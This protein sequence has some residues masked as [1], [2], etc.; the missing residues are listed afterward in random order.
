M[1]VEQLINYLR[2]LPQDSTVQCLVEVSRRYETVTVWKNL[3]I[4]DHINICGKYVE[5]GDK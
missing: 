5:I 4:E 1:T 3:K 2:T